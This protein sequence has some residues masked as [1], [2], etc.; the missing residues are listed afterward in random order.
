MGLI[1][2]ALNRD[3]PPAGQGRP[4]KVTHHEYAE[5]PGSTYFVDGR[6][7]WFSEE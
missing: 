1:G 6:L 5:T 4:R 7:T 2:T 3:R